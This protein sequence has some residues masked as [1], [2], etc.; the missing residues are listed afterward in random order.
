M[1]CIVRETLEISSESR[2]WKSIQQISAGSSSLH[3]EFK[4]RVLIFKGTSLKLFRNEF[5]FVSF[6][7]DVALTALGLSEDDYQYLACDVDFVI[8][9]AAYVN[10]IYPYSVRA[11]N[12]YHCSVMIPVLI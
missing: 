10:L 7:G 11:T 8:H 1:V 3:Q 12:Y 9:A 5:Y 6:L 4:S 2:L